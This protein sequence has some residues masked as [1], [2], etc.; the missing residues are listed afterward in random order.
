MSFFDEF[1]ENERTTSEPERENMTANDENNDI[2]TKSSDG[3]TRVYG[4][5]YGPKE[6]DYTDRGNGE[7]TYIPYSSRVYG[8]SQSSV[9]DKPKKKSRAGMIVLVAVLLLLCITLSA[10][11]AFLGTL[12][13]RSYAGSGE[14][15]STESTMQPTGVRDP[16]NIIISSGINTSYVDQD[17]HMSYAKAAAKAKDSVVEITTEIAVYSK[18]YGNYIST[19]A[20]SGVIIDANGYIVT[21][22]HVIEGATSVTVRLTNGHE[23]A[24]EL[25]GTDS[26]S[27]I[28]LIKITPNEELTVAVMGQSKNLVLGEE[29]LVIGNPLGELGGT[30]TNGI[31]SA[32]DRQM[33]VDGKRMTLLQTNAAVN[34]G[35]SGGGMFNLYGELV[36]VVNAKS[37]GEEV[38]GLGFAIPID[39][40]LQK[41]DD[42]SRYGYVKGYAD[43][44][45]GY[46]YGS[47]A[48]KDGW[49]TYT[50][51]GLIVTSVPSG[52]PLAV[53]D[54]IIAVEGASVKEQDD[55]IA[56]LSSYSI[57]DTVEV[58]VY[59]NKKN[60]TYSV[61]LAEY[62][63]QS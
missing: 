2:S 33:T 25:I 45:V 53:N 13:A 22:N 8:G 9:A 43:I 31:I 29:I 60:E 56:L 21:N 51:T 44:N 39:V 37:T 62:A 5:S 23:Y 3:D 17:D 46:K 32:L 10:G 52:S 26:I 28:A 34:P 57:G 38:E 55:I 63:P 6:G 18:Y 54:L 15:E 48:I 41:I 61:T 40:A 59:R 30:V 20:G 19:G 4:I 42:I 50:Y 11:A 47:V 14:D 12:F 27:D 7:Y 1:D 58:T 16:L 24:A 36:G 49:M 35:N